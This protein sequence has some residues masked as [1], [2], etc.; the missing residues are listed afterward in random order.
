MHLL[1]I[2]LCERQCFQ[3]GAC[4][5]ICCTVRLMECTRP[6]LFNIITI[7]LMMTMNTLVDT[8]TDGF[9][10]VMRNGAILSELRYFPS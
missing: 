10:S 6:N 8:E 1:T 4:S 9:Q 2:W 5:V 7:A 3:W